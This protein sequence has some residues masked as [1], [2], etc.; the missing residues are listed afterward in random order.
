V[1]NRI[2]LRLLCPRRLG[3]A[4]GCLRRDANVNFLLHK[5]ER[6]PD[7]GEKSLLG[8]AERLCLVKNGWYL[9]SHCAAL[10]NRVTQK[11]SLRARGAE[12][13]KTYFSCL[14]YT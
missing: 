2:G 13:V 7:T 12:C 4:G 5:L 9:D 11:K 10:A 1:K 6:L 8:M 3:K 14:S